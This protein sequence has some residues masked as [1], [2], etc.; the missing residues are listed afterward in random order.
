MHR[1]RRFRS[2]RLAG[3]LHHSLEEILFG[4]FAEG[5]GTE[6]FRHEIGEREGRIIQS[7]D[8]PTLPVELRRW[9]KLVQPQTRWDVMQITLHLPGCEWH[10]WARSAGALRHSRSGCEA[11]G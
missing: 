8:A 5:E 11:G 9:E 4:A 6:I 10:K 1:P 2:A 3:S 7:T